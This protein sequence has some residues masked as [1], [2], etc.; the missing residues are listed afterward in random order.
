[1]QLEQN[2][3]GVENAVGEL[4]AWG[5]ARAR[6]VKNPSTSALTPATRTRWHTHVAFHPNLVRWGTPLDDPSR[7]SYRG[8]PRREKSRIVGYPV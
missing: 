7:T 1:M 3:D 6:V 2:S 4:L 8:V 5:G